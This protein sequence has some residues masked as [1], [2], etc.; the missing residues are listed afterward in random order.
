ME[1]RNALIRFIQVVASLDNVP[2]N[3]WEHTI[4]TENKKGPTFDRLA[5]SSNQIRIS[6]Y[7]VVN[8]VVVDGQTEL[9]FC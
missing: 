9:F 3:S 8:L 1:V 4:G 6:M 2:I 7:L 5:P